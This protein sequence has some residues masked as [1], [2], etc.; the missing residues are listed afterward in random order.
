MQK[1]FCPDFISICNK[2]KK[3]IEFSSQQGY[4]NSCILRNRKDNENGF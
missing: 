4:N 2:K 1:I 3:K